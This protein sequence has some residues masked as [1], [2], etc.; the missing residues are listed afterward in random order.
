MRKRPH[1][2]S[3]NF[4][5]RFGRWRSARPLV[6]ILH[7]AA[8]RPFCVYQLL[9]FCQLLSNPSIDLEIEY[10]FGKPMK[11]RFQWFIL[12]TEILSTFQVRV[13]YISVQKIRH[14]AHSNHWGRKCWKIPKIASTFWGT[15]TPSNTWMPVATPLT[16]PN[17][18]RIHSAV[19]PQYTF[20]TDRPTDTHTEDRQMG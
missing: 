2:R 7:R 11:R 5:P 9:H 10:I 15:W 14:S 1:L 12:R 3:T 6:R 13:D 16:I 8:E 19:L 18:I 20:R 17:G 4:G